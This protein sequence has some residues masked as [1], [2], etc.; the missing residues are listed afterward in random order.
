ME[1]RWPGKNLEGE[2]EAGGARGGGELAQYFD[3]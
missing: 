3:A 1:V 2:V